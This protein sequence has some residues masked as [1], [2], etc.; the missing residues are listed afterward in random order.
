[1]VKIAGNFQVKSKQVFVIAKFDETGRFKR[2]TDRAFGC[3][4][5][6]FAVR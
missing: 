4:E 6:D 1:M 2:E 3:F 5:G